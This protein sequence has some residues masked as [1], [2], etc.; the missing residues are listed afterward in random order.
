[1]EFGGNPAAH[2]PVGGCCMQIDKRNGR[3]GQE[4]WAGMQGA[5]GVAPRRGRP[6]TAFF[7][8]LPADASA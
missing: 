6:V 1:M 8:G 2:P 7:R 5:G 4:D 3:H